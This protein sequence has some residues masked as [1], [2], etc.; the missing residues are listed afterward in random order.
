[1]KEK[2][3]SCLYCKYWNECHKGNPE[4][5]VH[6]EKFELREDFELI[7]YYTTELR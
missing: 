3:L 5:L 7:R 1:M 2:D 4:E 6:C